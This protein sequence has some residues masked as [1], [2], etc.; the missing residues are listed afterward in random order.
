MYVYKNHVVELALQ[1]VSGQTQQRYVYLDSV[2]STEDHS[3]IALGKAPSLS[4]CLLI[5]GAQLPVVRRLDS[6]FKHFVEIHSTT[7]LD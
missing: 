1:E 4:A 5:R 6:N 2:T 7:S 3:S